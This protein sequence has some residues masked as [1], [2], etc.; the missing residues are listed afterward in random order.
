[1]TTDAALPL[2]DPPTTALLDLADATGMLMI[3]EA[4]RNSSDARWRIAAR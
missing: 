2:F 3:V 4:R 1:M